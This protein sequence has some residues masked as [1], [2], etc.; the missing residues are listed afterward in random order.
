MKLRNAAFVLLSLIFLCG[1]VFVF[2]IRKSGALGESSIVITDVYLGDTGA[3]GHEFIRIYNN[4][5]E[6]ID[7]TNW[8]L[9]FASAAIYREIKCLTPPSANTGLFLRANTYGLLTSLEYSASNSQI[10]QDFIFSINTNIPG[11]NG[12]IRIVDQQ[13]NIIDRIGWGSGAAE[14]I[15]LGSLANGKMFKRVNNAESGY[16]DTDMNMNDF[17]ISDVI[18]I[19]ESGGV[20]DLEVEVDLCAN[21]NGTQIIID[22]GYLQDT[23]GNC[24]EDFCPNIEGLQLAAPSGYEKLQGSSICREIS[25]ENSVLLITEL[26]PNASSSDTGKEFIEIYNPN[27][28]TVDLAGYILQVGPGFT[29]QFTIS[30]G[31]INSGEYLA[32]S[33]TQSKIILPNTSGV[34]LR[35]VTPAGNIVSETPVY[36]N[37]PDDT[38]WALVNDQWLYTNRPT[39]A[40]ANLPYEESAVD[41]VLSVTS[42]LAPCTAGKYRNPET[43]RCRNIETA[44]SSLKPCDEDEYRNPDT[45]RC[46]K[47]ASGTVLAA[48]AVGQERNP[49]TN[50]C[51]KVSALSTTD[52]A[53]ATIEDVQVGNTPGQINWL[54]I[55]TALL[56]TFSYILYEWRSEIRQKYLAFRY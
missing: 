27:S 10:I 6:D 7:V 48:C 1:Q 28:W 39:P 45:N 21:I 44:V 26:L 25:L 36:S 5:S 53:L 40:T 2:E 3:S 55:S 18:T 17:V 9:E 24:F 42:V 43:N 51:R 46:R 15:G 19:I 52:A 22:E 33:D 49:E 41:E 50:R 32:Y 47:V 56:G 54:I 30:S 8:C 35:L 37:A 16:T 4:S 12:S 23:A 20:Y 29:K 14:G 38:T 11:T 13:H 34:Q 31:K